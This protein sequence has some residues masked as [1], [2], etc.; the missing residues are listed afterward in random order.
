MAEY[1][2]PWDGA[3]GVSGLS[4]RV[5]LLNIANDMV[6]RTS[7]PKCGASIAL[8]LL[9]LCLAWMNEVPKIPRQICSRSR[10]RLDD[11]QTLS[12]D[13][14]AVEIPIDKV[15][16]TEGQ[17]LCLCFCEASSSA[18]FQFF[19]IQ[20]PQKN[21]FDHGAGQNGCGLPFTLV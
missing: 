21:R 13:D 5:P 10:V 17:F 19:L 7:R 9:P 16:A 4:Q 1:L 15:R 12:N 6:E 2:A 18:G 3:R 11:L 8:L 20:C 14:V